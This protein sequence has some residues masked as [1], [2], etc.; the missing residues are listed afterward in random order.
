M[1][2]TEKSEMFM[3]KLKAFFCIYFD[4]Q[5]Y[6]QK[7]FQIQLITPFNKLKYQQMNL[8]IANIKLEI[9]DHF[10][11]KTQKNQKRMARRNFVTIVLD[12]SN[13]FGSITFYGF[14]D[15]CRGE[16]DYND[17]GNNPRIHFLS[18]QRLFKE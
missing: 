10:L 2:Q 18:C 11:S 3:I 9:S 5:L 15:F 6:R 8:L 17:Y 4:I 12:F 7:E 16:F 14:F 13:V 1:R